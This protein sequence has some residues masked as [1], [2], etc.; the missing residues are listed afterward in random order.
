MAG[1]KF[2][3]LGIIFF[4]SGLCNAKLRPNADAEAVSCFRRIIGANRNCPVTHFARA[5]IGSQDEARVAAKSGL[6]LDQSLTIRRYRN[7]A[8]S[9]N[10]TYLE[11]E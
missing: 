9:D 3:N 4:D 1:E 11:P 6:A 8:M 5:R 2:S 7:G 10:L